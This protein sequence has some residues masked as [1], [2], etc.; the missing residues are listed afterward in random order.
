[1]TDNPPWDGPSQFPASTRG[2]LTLNADVERFALAGNA[3]LTVVSLK[4]N[5]RYTFKVRKP[6]DFKVERPMWF[7]STLTGA[8]NE[9]DF[10]YIGQIKLIGGL[11]RYERGRKCWTTCYPQ[12][13]AFAWFWK[14][15]TLR[16]E[17]EVHGSIE[18]W[19]EGR[20][21]KCGRKLTVPSSIDSGF[22]PE[23]GEKV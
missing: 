15:T 8:D 17:P 3:T 6:D 2:R 7:V 14:Q 11:Y 18:V 20:C 1:M 10:G 19:H 4:T 13:E 22:G 5:L 12:S 21:G 9:R 16:T 23:C